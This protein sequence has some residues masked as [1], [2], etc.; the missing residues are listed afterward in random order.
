MTLYG[1]GLRLNEGCHLRPTDIES[2]RMMIRVHQGKG[3]KDRY[4]ILSA[5]LLEEL[6][7]YWRACHHASSPW[8]FH[9]SRD[10]QRPLCDHVAQNVFYAA[11]QRAGLPNRGGIHSLRHSF[12]THLLE[13]GVEIMVL[14]KLL[15]H[16]SLKT[17]CGYL[18]VS[19]ER[20]AQVRSPLDGLALDAASSRP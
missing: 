11:L 9:S 18:H 4:T 2:S 6:R 10:P 20:I 15:G 5:W 14:K 19:E 13:S 17:T 8:L 16:G 12:A 3:A 7:G 1:A